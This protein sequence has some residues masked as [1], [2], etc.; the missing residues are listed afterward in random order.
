MTTTLRTVLTAFEDARQPLSLKE[1]AVQLDVTPGLLDG[2]LAHWIRKGK[3]REVS[4][5][6][7]CGSC[8]G[9]AGCPFMMH[10]PRTYELVTDIPIADGAPPALPAR[11]GCGCGGCF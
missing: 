11:P 10:M 8:G 9:A 5:A 6:T 4:S 1:L 7:T 3:L 2:M